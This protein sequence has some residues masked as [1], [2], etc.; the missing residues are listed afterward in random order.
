M[1]EKWKKTTAI[2]LSCVFLLLSV[3]VEFSHHHNAPHQQTTLTENQSD[4]G[5][6]QSGQRHSLTCIACLFS[7]TH[8]APS[9]TIQTL[10]TYQESHFAT[11]DDA[12]FY[13]VTLATPYYLRAPPA[14]TT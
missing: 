12:V 7:L 14:L 6:L 13:S 11:L 5:D 1:K 8:L 2:F 4:A 9:L 3:A 10:K